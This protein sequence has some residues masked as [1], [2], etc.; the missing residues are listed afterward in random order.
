V[1]EANRSW[2]SSS[3]ANDH[4]AI[5]I[6]VS[7]SENGGNW[8]VSDKVL[9]KLIDLCVD[10]CQRNGIDKLNYTGDK[11]G[12]LTM[13]KWFANT[14]CP[15]PYL[16]SKFPY[17]AEEVNKRLAKEEK[18]VIYRVQVGAYSVKE[19]AE[20]MAERLQADGYQTIIKEEVIET[21]TSQM[22]EVKPEPVKKI[23]EGSVVRVKQGAL[24]YDGVQLADFVYNR[25]HIVKSISGNR[26]VIT[27]ND[28]VVA[29]VHKDN[30]IEI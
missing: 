29:A 9:S 14:A 7:N 1:D 4:R 20:K 25:N 5:T 15:G 27:Y 13:H 24:T 16:G 23:E 2:C 3:S 21:V 17:I 30:L 10:I 6:E 19:N 28:I 11:N 8:P 12:N 26:V 22:P 18:K